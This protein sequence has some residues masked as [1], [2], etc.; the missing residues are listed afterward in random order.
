MMIQAMH[1]PR[2]CAHG[3]ARVWE[4]RHSFSPRESEMRMDTLSGRR[5][6][7]VLQASARVIAEAEAIREASSH[8]R[9]ESQQRLEESH[10]LLGRSRRLLAQ[11]QALR[12]MPPSL[13]TNPQRSQTASA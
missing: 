8:V 5:V 12:S 3:R 7:A 13:G 1:E 10:A 6:T 2:Y 4:Q 11:A 9:A